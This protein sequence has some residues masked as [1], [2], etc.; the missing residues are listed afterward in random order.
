LA[1]FP[2][3]ERPGEQQKKDPAQMAGSFSI[4]SYQLIEIKPVVF[5]LR[6]FS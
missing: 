3:L 1:Y 4:E 5:D 2:P 6:G